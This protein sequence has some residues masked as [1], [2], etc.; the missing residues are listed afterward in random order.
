MKEISPTSQNC[1]S[2][3][4][5]S[6]KAYALRM[7]TIQIWRGCMTSL[8]LISRWCW[9]SKYLSNIERNLWWSSSLLDKSLLWLRR[10]DVS[11]LVVIL[12][13]IWL[14]HSLEFDASSLFLRF[15]L[16]TFLR[17][18]LLLFVDVAVTLEP[19]KAYLV[20]FLLVS[21]NA[22]IVGGRTTCLRSIQYDL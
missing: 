5:H 15:S 3:C 9:T 7:I 21:D 11:F 4:F 12:F 20:D 6:S 1:T 16:R 8:R 19:A 13:V 14:S 18:L 17:V 2:S 10:Y 22:F